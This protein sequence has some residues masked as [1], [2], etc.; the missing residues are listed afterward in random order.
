MASI[1]A[2]HKA[3]EPPGSDAARIRPPSPTRLTDDTGRVLLTF[4]APEAG[5]WVTV[6]KVAD[7]PEAARRE[8]IVVDLTRSPEER[9][10]GEWVEVADLRTKGPDGTYPTR[11]VRRLDWER[12][13]APSEPGTKPAAGHDSAGGAAHAAN[14]GKLVMYSTKYCPVCRKA[15][16]FLDVMG[17]PYTDK[18]V[19]QDAAAARELARKARKAGIS[20]TGVPVFE[21]RG[22]MLQGF[23]EKALLRLLRSR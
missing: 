23:D 14:P 9:G 15:R 18:D 3:E 8:V 10:A 19:E 4:Q 22:R 1:A 13:R 2:C 7:V 16:R 17:I 20:P 12:S 5:T 21:Y 11:M 6:D